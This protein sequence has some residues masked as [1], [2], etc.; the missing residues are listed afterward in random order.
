MSD[1]P[2]RPA[3]YADLEAVPDHLVA[4]IIDG[5]LVT[6]HHGYLAPACARTMLSFNLRTL[7]QKRSAPDAPWQIVTLPE[8]HL[9]R[10]VVVPELA[11]WSV[12]RLP[13]LTD[14]LVDIAP[15]WA[16]ELTSDGS[17]MNPALPE[18][19]ELY[20]SVGVRFMWIV[21]LRPASVAAFENDAGRWTKIGNWNAADTVRAPPFDAISFS[22]ADLWPLDRPLGMNED[23]TPY[24]AGDR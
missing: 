11:A 19:I 4:E 15:D 17:G 2:K 6:R 13:Y 24:Y 9:G 21:N 7:S 14:E 22:L 16:C 10:D 12:A 23:P 3:T 20:R 5:V 8:L 18:K 1:A